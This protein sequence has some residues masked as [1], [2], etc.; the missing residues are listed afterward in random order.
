MTATA[1]AAAFEEIAD[2]A[3]ATAICA[4]G[5]GLCRAVPHHRRDRVVRRPDRAGRARAHLRP[6]RSA[7]AACRPRR[8]RRSGRRHLA[9]GDAQRSVAQPADAAR[10]SGSTCRSGASRS[11]A[12][13][14]AQVLGARE[15]CLT[16][17]AKLSGAPTVRVALRAAAGG[18]RGRERWK[19]ALQ[20]GERYLAMARD[21]DRPD[22]KPQPMARP[23]PKP[24]RA[25]RPTS[26]SVTEIETWLRDPYSIYARHVLELAAARR[27]S[28]RRRARAT[29]AS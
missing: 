8:A 20:R 9:A 11:R 19:A 13:D 28:T 27:R 21:L 25:A 23:E 29:A 6:A 1:L 12:H 22:S 17:P 5:D 24:P 3:T 7:P 4:A 26:L 18:G 16:Y 15:V 14:F 10:R 2:N